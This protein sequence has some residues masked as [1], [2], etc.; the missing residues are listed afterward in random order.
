[1]LIIGG[2][3]VIPLIWAMGRAENIWQLAT[4][5]AVVWF[6]YGI[7]IATI[8]TLAGLF[9]SKDERGKVL[10]FLGMS[11]GIGTIIGGLTIGPLVDR[12]GYQTMFLVLCL[13]SVLHP[14]ICLFIK[15]KKIERYIPDAPSKRRSNSRYGKVFIVLILAQF[16]ATIVMGFAGMGRSFAMRNLD[17]TATAITSTGVVAGIICL[18][19]PFIIGWLSDL[20]G[21]KRLLAICYGSFTL[22]MVIFAIS[23]SLW[24]FWIGAMLVQIGQVSSSVGTAFVADLVEP[25]MLGR[26][27][28]VFQGMRW[29]GFCLGLATAGYAFQSLGITTAMFA[30]TAFPAIGII[31]IMLT[32]AKKREEMIAA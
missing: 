25:K 2:T 11:S 17:F 9:T 24:H 31:L 21:R 14:A 23:K 28:S 19:F 18:P 15:D 29:A 27:V 1:M 30:S 13:F 10:G 26:G 5:T 20:L 22:C 8:S 3:I 4:A 6:L 12:W 7:A 16:V 32:R